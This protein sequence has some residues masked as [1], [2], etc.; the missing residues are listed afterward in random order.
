[1]PFCAWP[2]GDSCS[3]SKFMLRD[4]NNVVVSENVCENSPVSRV[5]ASALAGDGFHG[6]PSSISLS[7][8]KELK[9]NG[10]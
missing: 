7:V 2:G 5:C 3:S 8:W 9:E 10:G 6:S 1:M 4:G